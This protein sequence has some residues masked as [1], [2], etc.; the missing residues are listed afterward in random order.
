M[1]GFI[2]RKVSVVQFNCE[3]DESFLKA[4]LLSAAMYAPVL[5]DE[6]CAMPYPIAIIL[7]IKT[8]GQMIRDLNVWGTP[9]VLDGSMSLSRCKTK[10]KEGNSQMSFLVYS[11]S[12]RYGELIDFICDAVSSGSVDDR[13]LTVL[14]VVLFQ[15]TLP[16][17]YRDKFFVV[18][19]SNLGRNSVRREEILVSAEDIPRVLGVAA[20]KSYEPLKA[21]LVT[22]ACFLREIIDQDLRPELGLLEKMVD[23]I[24]RQEEEA[25]DDSGIAEAFVHY[26]YKWKESSKFHAVYPLPY[27]E[28]DA[29]QNLE[30]IVLYDREYAY[31]SETIF[32][33][34]VAP[35]R[36]TFSLPTIKKALKK[37]GILV[38]TDENTYSTKVGFYGVYGQFIR[39]RRFKMVLEKINQPGEIPFIDLCEQGGTEW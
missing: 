32:Q 9:I 6:G 19:E 10:L 21:A 5:Q 12:G 39:V 11:N 13:A 16:E 8:P 3:I 14:P 29:I 15:G 31:F 28:Q 18:P 33:E 2:Q 7:E 20:S 25:K 23:R 30:S 1:V 34:I 35:F 36:S 27:V 17:K 4:L 38:S 26:L 24:I 37:E 22:A